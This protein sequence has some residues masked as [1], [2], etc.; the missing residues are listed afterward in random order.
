MVFDYLLKINQYFEQGEK[1]ELSNYLQLF[2][3]HLKNTLD[4]PVNLTNHALKCF[5]K[6]S[7]KNSN[8]IKF[9]VLYSG[10]FK[11]FQNSIFEYVNKLINTLTNEKK[12]IKLTDFQLRGQTGW[13]L[14]F[15]FIV[16]KDQKAD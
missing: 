4:S 16:L 13:L 8:R 7:S 3:D 5:L 9:K 6:L 15:S 2:I 10:I 14:L 12:Y 11:K 1:K